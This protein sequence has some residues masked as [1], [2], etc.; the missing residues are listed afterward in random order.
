MYTRRFCA[1][2]KLAQQGGREHV[3]NQR[4]L[5]RAADTGDAHQALQRKLDAQVLQVVLARAFE[6]QAWR[7]VGDQ[8]LQA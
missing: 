2:P 7:V 8:A 4:R 1:S 3:L 5:T 6:N